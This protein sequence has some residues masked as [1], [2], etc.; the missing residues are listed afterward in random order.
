LLEVEIELGGRLGGEEVDRN[1]RKD[2]EDFFHEGV[3]QSLAA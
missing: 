2:G 1:E 3:S